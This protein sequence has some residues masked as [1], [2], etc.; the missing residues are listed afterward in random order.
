MGILLQSF[1][2]EAHVFEPYMRYRD[3][4]G[5]SVKPGRHFGGIL[6]SEAR[7]AKVLKFVRIHRV[8]QLFR[9]VRNSTHH[10]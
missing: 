10:G 5:L 8:F 6:K 2:H 1:H 9:L 4:T 7:N 3:V